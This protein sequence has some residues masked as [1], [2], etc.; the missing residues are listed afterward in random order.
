MTAKLDFPATHRNKHAISEVLAPRLPMGDVIEVASGSGQHV[1][2]FAPLF[3]DNV[4]WPTDFEADHVQSVDAWVLSTGVSNVKAAVQL[5]VT[6]EDW[7]TG[8]A[9]DG[10]PDQCAAIFCANMIHIAPIEA[11]HGLFEGAGK[12][13]TKGGKLFLYGPFLGMAKDAPSN[14]EFDA[15]LQSRNPAWGVRHMVEVRMS[16]KLQGFDLMETVPMPANNF[17]LV[18]EKG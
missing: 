9:I 8:K 17:V 11:M 2:H 14:K 1:T 4:F 16:A 10:L 6:G 7:R 18:F 15:S 3:G 12:R 5:D 13:I